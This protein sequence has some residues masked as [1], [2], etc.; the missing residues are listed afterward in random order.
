MATAA[1]TV[2]SSSSAQATDP[3]ADDASVAGPTCPPL[4]LPAVSRRIYRRSSLASATPHRGHAPRLPGPKPHAAASRSSDARN[5]PL[6]EA[7]SSSHSGG[8]R[9][10]NAPTAEQGD[11]SPSLQR[12]P[13]ID[14]SMAASTATGAFAAGMPKPGRRLDRLLTIRPQ[15]APAGAPGRDRPGRQSCHLAPLGVHKHWPRAA[16]T[17]HH[18]R[19]RCVGR[20]AAACVEVLCARAEIAPP[21]IWP[22]MLCPKPTHAPARRRVTRLTAT[23]SKRGH[24]PQESPRRSAVHQHLAGPRRA[25]EAREVLSRPPAELAHSP[26]C[27][28]RATR[29]RAAREAPWLFQAAP[30]VCRRNLSER[31]V[32]RGLASTAGMIGFTA[33]IYC[34]PD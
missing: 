21:N 24:S 33:G 4:A 17:D 5:S 2:S 11:G 34:R 8:P 22:S 19:Q 20:A 13:T 10:K 27:E 30:R 12:A 3:S 26:L 32:R 6:S 18:R 28:A 7:T 14:G 16:V 31:V 25:L 29:R 1:S 15:H 9:T 23:A